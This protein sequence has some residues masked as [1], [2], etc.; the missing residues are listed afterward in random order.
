MSWGGEIEWNERKMKMG[1]EKIEVA[2]GKTYQT[3]AN[4]PLN[5]NTMSSLDGID[6]HRREGRQK[7]GSRLSLPHPSNPHQPSLG[8]LN[9]P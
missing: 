7:P 6:R 4:V 9:S 2:A 3:D 8:Y 5:L 1:T